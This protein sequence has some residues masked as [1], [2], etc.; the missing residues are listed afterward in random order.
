MSGAVRS[1][2]EVL[3]LL[4]DEFPEIT[5]SKIRF[6]ES[7]GLLS[8]E[9]TP[10][11]YR[12]FRDGDVDRLRWILAQQ[13]DNFL[14]LRVIRQRLDADDWSVDEIG[15]SDIDDAPHAVPVYVEP[16]P[17]FDLDSSAGRYGIEELATSAGLD[18]AEVRDLLRFGV[19][20]PVVT[21]PAPIFDDDSL[22]IAKA[23]KVFMERGVEPRHLKSWRLAA[24]RE[25]NIIEQLVAPMT[26]SGADDAM[27]GALELAS[28]LVKLG[29]DLRYAMLRGS[30]RPALGTD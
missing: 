29:G 7:Q 20:D 25:A 12:K 26:H 10:S 21:E 22:V 18:I 6:L 28:E 4:E 17:T 14:P 30:L 15:S 13:R 2:G 8:P 11:G 24:D 9:R 1:I 27:A 5:I 23:A 16:E 19:L 3:H